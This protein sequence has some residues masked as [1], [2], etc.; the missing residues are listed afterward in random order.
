[1]ASGLSV[2]C[3]TLFRVAGES[4]ISRPTNGLDIAHTTTTNTSHYLKLLIN[5]CG[6]QKCDKKQ[7]FLCF[8]LWICVFSRFPLWTK[9]IAPFCTAELRLL[10]RWDMVRPRWEQNMMVGMC[11][12]A[13]LVMLTIWE[14]PAGAS[15]CHRG[16]LMSDAVKTMLASH[17]KLFSLPLLQ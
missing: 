5:F 3:I 14:D 10:V 8:Y 1:M 15:F 9:I 13:F 12:S 6:E 7:T 17:S 4:M 2:R 11:S 16:F